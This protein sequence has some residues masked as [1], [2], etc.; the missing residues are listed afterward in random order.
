MKQNGGVSILVQY[1]TCTY[2]ILTF[3][4]SLCPA[5]ISGSKYLNLL[6]IQNV[7]QASKAPV[8]SLTMYYSVCSVSQDGCAHVFA[9]FVVG[10]V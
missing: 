10:I 8:S 9:L 2:P 4:N 3:L 6:I 7:S 5:L 1:C